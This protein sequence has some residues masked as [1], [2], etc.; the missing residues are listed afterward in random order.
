VYDVLPA[1]NNALNDY[2]INGSPVSGLSSP[3]RMKQR[4]IEHDC[5]AAVR[6]FA[7]AEHLGNALDGIAGVIKT[8]S[9]GC[10]PLSE[11][12]IFIISRAIIPF[13]ITALLLNR[14]K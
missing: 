1:L 2:A 8:F 13:S 5:I 6:L 10:S 11:D 9:H 3:L 4:L 14:H 12:S 7:A